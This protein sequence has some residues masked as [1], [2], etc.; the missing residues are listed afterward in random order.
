MA[1]MGTRAADGDAMKNRRR[2]T[3]RT[4]RPSAP[5]VRGRRKTSS[6]N[7]NTKIALFKRERD[8]ALEQQNATAEVL[9]VISSSPGE[10]E[11]VFQAMLA[12]AV[13]ICEAK[14]GTLY[15]REGDAFRAAALHNAPPAFAEFWQRGPHR[16]GASTVLSRVLR[17]KE[18]VHISDITADHAYIE[19]DPLFIAAA[20][21]GGFRTVL[22]VPMLKEADVLGAIYIYRQEVWPFSDNQ[23]ALLASFASQAV[24]A[25]E[26]TRLLNELR[27][28]TADLTE[29]LEQQTATS[30][31]LKILSFSPGDLKPVFQTMLENATRICHA[32][33]GVLQLYEG[34][35]FRIGAIHNAPPAFAEAMARRELLMRPTPQHPFTRMVTTKEVVQIADL[36]DSPAYKERD[37][38]VVMLV[39]LA[40]ARTF[41]AVPMLKENEVVGVIAIYRQEVL[42]FTDKQVEL[43]KNF[44]AQAVIAIENTRLLNE[45]RQRTDDLTESLEQQTATSEVL[46]VISSSPGE[47]EPVFQALLENAVRI[48]DA[49][50]GT[51]YR[52]DGKTFD[53]GAQFGTPPELAE[54][55]KRRGSFLPTPGGT[56][57]RAIRTKQVSQTADMSA[58]SVPEPPATLGGARSVV[59]VPMLKDEALIGT[60]NVYRQEARP[61][62]EKQIELLTNFAAQAV[63]AIENTRLLNELRE[64]LQ[65]QTATADVLKVISRSTFDLQTVL[66]ALIKSAA[67][68]CDADIGCILRPQGS[69]FEFVANYQMPQAF[70]DLVTAT[71]V[72]S[73]RGTLAGRVLLGG[74]TV[75]LPDA[76]ADSE[77]T[78]RSALTVVPFRSGLGVPLLRERIPIGVLILW[79][80]QLRPFTDSQIALVTTFAD[81]AVIAIENVRLFEAEQQRTRELSASLEQQTAT[82]DVL[83]VIS[84]SPGEL[85][86]VF[87]AMLEKAMHL[88]EAAFG[89]LW[90]LEENRYVAVALRGVPHPYAAFL[91]ETTVIPGP[92]TAV[93]RFMHGEPL[94]H[95]VDLAS[96]EAYRAGDPQRRALVDLGGARTAL[97]VPLRKED[98]VLG[99]I[100][101]Y[102]QEVRPFTEKQ[103]DLLKNFAAQAV[104]AIENTRLLNELRQR[105]TDLTESLEQQTATSEVLSVISSSPGE[106]EPVFQAMLANATRLCEANFG[107][108]HLR[109]SGAFRVGAMHNVPA[110]FAQ[111]VVL[112]GP[113]LQPGPAH[114]LARMAAAKQ[115]IHVFDYAEDPAYTQREPAAVRLV[116]LAGAR[117]VIAVPML[118]DDELVGA[119]TIFRQ[120]VRPF[121]DKQIAL[122][123]N[124]AAQAVI[125]IENTRLL[126]ELRQRT[127]DLTESLEQQTATS[128]V[129]RIISSSPGELESVFQAMLE[130]AVRI[131]NA[132]FGNLLLFDGKDMRV[133]AMHNAPREHA[134]MR[135]RNPVIPLDRSIAGPLVRTKKLVVV[136]DIT[137]E[138]PY[139]SSPLAKVGGARTALAV[140]MLREDVLV[141]AFTIYRGEVRPFTNKQIELV[142]NFAAQ[143]VIAIEN[144]R[145]LSELRQSLERQTATS[146]VLQ[147]IS[148]SPGELEPVFQTMLENATRICE[149]QSGILWLQE[150]DG[151]RSVATHGV[152]MAAV[153]ARRAEPFIRPHPD[154]P[155][156]RVMRT[157]KTIH[158][159]DLKEDKSYIERIQPV[160]I[161][162]DQGGARSLL[163]VPML[164]DD[165]FLGTIAIYR[166]VVRPF[167]DKQIELVKN[168]AAQAVIAIENTRLLNELRQSLQQQTATAD[169]LKV[170]SRSTFD[171]QTVLQ[172]LVESAARLC[173]ADK[174]TITRQKDEVFYRAESYGFSPDFMEYVKNVPV[175]RERGS[176][177][178][179]ALL[180]GRVIHIPDVQADPEYTFVEAQRL[181][182]FRTV[183]GVPM[184]RESA[185]IGVLALTRSEVRPFTDKQIELVSTFADQA[186][187]AIENVR[188]FDEI[189]DKSRQLEVAS[190][191]KSQ[192][193]ANMSH[194]LRTPLNAILGYTE[195]MADGIYGE[196]PEKTMGVLKRLES[197]GRHLLG[198]INDVLD[199][200][201]IEAGQ[202]VLELTDYSLEDIAQT[203]R[204]TLEPLAA[205]KRLAFKVEVAPKMP[206]GYGD[207]RRLTQVVINL[208]GNAIK[209]TDA[210][211]V[212]IK[213]TATDGS[214]HLS[215]RDT[216]PGISAADQA[217]L[218]QEFQQADNAITRRKGG[219]GLGLAIS[220]RIIEMH[221]G[222]ISVESQVGKGSTFSFTVPVRVALQ[223]PTA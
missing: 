117:S 43:V 34:R 42:T 67:Q 190:Q 86:P 170:I 65:Q 189:Q 4:K 120:E 27:Q 192:F 108:L 177:L 207:G 161:L 205:D 7:A 143:A 90:T 220:K 195:L 179:R 36:T 89:G 194:E 129:L 41:L 55:Q 172:T 169:V 191:H 71:P 215:V 57:D 12:N 110:A 28:R 138:E 218:F 106:L 21:L 122:V 212:V 124:F 38:G 148:S 92:G 202:L 197:N 100:T 22:A 180:E 76:L 137:A 154:I 104:I 149:A 217:K 221:G 128:E 63:I 97:H 174:A 9:R 82:A 18:V 162:V 113:L 83:R 25:I 69:H 99:V 158:I 85:E 109:E 125:A 139:A 44:A 123:R 19:R 119:I 151:L 16:P 171:L 160:P 130:N 17:T 115:L 79:R 2:T 184:L 152:P 64:S 103:I 3:T 145:L 213:A 84:S 198:L 136:A 70:V 144:T 45:L 56:F 72:E 176:V 91:A 87:E 15:L 173:E 142:Q 188:L 199:L 193:L 163:M 77:Y 93:Y 107:L 203:V 32:K 114:P 53:F 24:I 61:F 60:V 10:L 29:S 49:K 222:K 68:L 74:H 223:V 167:T 186:A 209:F 159:V 146:E 52:F 46:K 153:N 134:E 30:E 75:H 51:M 206:P 1:L 164:K 101:L 102:R 196:L 88:C 111:A 155:L 105:T 116:E 11:P 168:F 78:F 200:S 58:Q 118:N 140:P 13:R 141:G 8:E 35:A 182:D 96:E 98:A 204:S 20:E 94:V 181:G 66:D 112:R 47:L 135:R 183:L 166:P 48:C 133:V 14:F 6:S 121:T 131:C 127:D 132:R 73:G 178:G 147:V 31:V 210:G 80:S 59:C 175:E 54:F 5:K 95:N 150:Q 37:Y 23:I 50:F 185:P 219:T 187:I 165:E 157:Q 26:N 39:E 126:N 216:G 40:S 211:E 201:K 62:T 214:F 156:G 208:V 81:Q 33:F